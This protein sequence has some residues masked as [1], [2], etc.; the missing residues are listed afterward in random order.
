MLVRL[1]T[2]LLYRRLQWLGCARTRRTAHLDRFEHKTGGLDENEKEMLMQCVDDNWSVTLH[3][4][5]RFVNYNYCIINVLCKSVLT[6]QCPLCRTCPAD[7]HQLDENLYNLST[8]ENKH[9]I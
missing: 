4:V 1:T 2:K 7:F 6:L 5:Q 3:L 9:Q 8:E